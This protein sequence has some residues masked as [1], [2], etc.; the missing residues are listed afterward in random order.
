MTNFKPIIFENHLLTVDGDDWKVVGVGAVNEDR[1]V[2]LHLASLTRFRQQ[3]NG[4]SPVQMAEWFP[5]SL[6]EVAA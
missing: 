2:Y 4:N 3:K 1:Q 5:L 6:F